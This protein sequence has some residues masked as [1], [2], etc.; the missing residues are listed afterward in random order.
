[1]RSELD[2]LLAGTAAQAGVRLVESC[3][4]KSV[5]LRDHDAEIISGRGNFFA[6]FVIAADG[7]HSP[8]A[9]AAGWS[10]LPS[11]APALEQEIYLSSED[12]ERFNAMPRFDFNAIDAGYAWVFP[13]RDHLSVGIVSTRSVCRGLAGK[14]RA[15][16][17]PIG[18]HPRPKN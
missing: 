16:S 11:L 17:A 18:N 13:K 4:V 15:I 8:T 10:G 14:T 9:R 1:M 6:K 3:P 12:L 7:V 2:S 5:N